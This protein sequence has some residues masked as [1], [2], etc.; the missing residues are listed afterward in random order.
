MDYRFV[1]E[2]MINRIRREGRSDMLTEETIGFIHSLD[3]KVGTDYNWQ[4]QVMGE[5]LVWLQ[6][7]QTYVNIVDCEV[8]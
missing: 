6:E 2:K 4:S 3:G 8:V 1:A 7:A 5:P